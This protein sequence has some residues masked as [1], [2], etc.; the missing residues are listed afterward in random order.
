VERFSL[1]G[2][3]LGPAVCHLPAAHALAARRSGDAIYREQLP[4][5]PP[6][7]RALGAG[8]LR[9]PHT[10]RALG[11]GLVLAAVALAYVPGFY[12]V[13]Q[14]L[15]AWAPVEVDYT[16]ALSGWVPWVEGMHV[17]LTASFGEELLFRV[18]GVLLIVKV[19]R[20]RW[21]AVVI[22]CTIWAFLHSG[23]AQMPGYLRGIELTVEGVLW[24]WAVL[25][26]GVVSTLTA[27]YLFN[28]TLSS[29]VV[30]QSPSWWN[31]AGA[32]A[33]CAWPVVLF[34]W[35]CWKCRAPV[36]EQ[37]APVAEPLPT[38]PEAAPE[39]APVQRWDFTPRRFSTR[40][41][42]LGIGAALAR[43]RRAVLPAV[44][45]RA[46]FDHG[47]LELNRSQITEAADREL[48]NRGIDPTPW[49]RV[50]T[51]S[52]GSTSAR[53]LLRFRSLDDLAKLF[54][55]EIPEASWSVRYFQIGERE[56]FSV[57]LDKSGKVQR[58]SHSISK[59]TPGATLERDAALALA[60]QDLKKT[61]GF[62]EEQETLVSEWS[63]QQEN[64]RD[65]YFEWKRR[66]WSW[67]EAELRT[68]CAG[69]G[70]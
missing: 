43:P 40:Q 68:S 26:F 32:I 55:S 6:L 25:R 33:V 38:P 42:W 47:T 48:R 9:D 52:G 14:K 67:G 45:L 29:V 58:W 35:G 60:I 24:G 51:V 16:T 54:G 27:H 57:S 39:P 44:A 65:H 46:I 5:H 11:I 17:G 15:G 30:F 8:A 2:G 62:A 37:A 53:Y 31:K 66:D 1:R 63:T 64:R 61:H 19:I 21:A 36:A 56:E 28:C 10:V 4:E 50:A 23:Y 18:I 70:R 49:R 20:S 41:R 3:A 34:L 13:S 12:I 22:A 69:A 7:R 59:E